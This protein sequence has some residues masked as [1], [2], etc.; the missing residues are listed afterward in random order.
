MN[1]YGLRVG[2]LL[3]VLQESILVTILVNSDLHDYVNRVQGTW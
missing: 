1:G 2:G 3:K